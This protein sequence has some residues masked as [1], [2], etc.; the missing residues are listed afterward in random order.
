MSDTS[1]RPASLS[2]RLQREPEIRYTREGVANTRL[3]VEVTDGDREYLFDVLATDD[4]AENIAL[5][6]TKNMYVTVIG[7]LVSNV[8][9]DDD[10]VY[11]H[12]V[13]ILATDVGASLRRATVDVHNVTVRGVPV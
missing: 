3:V 1:T 13:E 8:W 6:L 2:G 5:S 12:T 10:G 9:T 4:L 11:H 7:K